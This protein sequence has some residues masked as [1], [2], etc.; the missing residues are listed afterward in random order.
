MLLTEKQTEHYLD[1]MIQWYSIPERDETGK[2]KKAFEDMKVV[3]FGDDYDESKR[4][5]IT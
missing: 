1:E 5:K 4:A 2:K 3:L